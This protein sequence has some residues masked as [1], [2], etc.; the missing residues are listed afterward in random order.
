M[1]RESYK[2]HVPFQNLQLHFFNVHFA[3]I[4]IAKNKSLSFLYDFHAWLEVCFTVSNRMK[5]PFDPRF[6]S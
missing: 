1:F 3:L 5:Q 4:W 2:T 6:S